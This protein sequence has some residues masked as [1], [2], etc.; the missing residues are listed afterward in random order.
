VFSP[1]KG[2]S[3]YS[4]ILVS[5]YGAN[6]KDFFI[7]KIEVS[8][9]GKDI[10]IQV[11]SGITDAIYMRESNPNESGASVFVWAQQGFKET[12]ASDF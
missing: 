1:K 12:Q 11:R 8:I 5:E 4:S 3:E 6:S 9:L 7:R 2:S 10:R